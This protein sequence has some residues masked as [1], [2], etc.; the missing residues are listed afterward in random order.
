MKDF[1]IYYFKVLLIYFGLKKTLVNHRHYDRNLKNEIK[2]MD[3]HLIF[4]DQING[5][6]YDSI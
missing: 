5:E 3:N 1:S 4:N 2:I 6:Y